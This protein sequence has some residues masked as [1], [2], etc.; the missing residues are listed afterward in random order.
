MYAYPECKTG[1]LEMC[2]CN[3]IYRESTRL[4]AQSGAAQPHLFQWMTVLLLT[5]WLLVVAVAA[6]NA[7]AEDASTSRSLQ[8]FIEELL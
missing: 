4:S 3:C 2:V 8:T 6:K 1:R 5:G 7:Q